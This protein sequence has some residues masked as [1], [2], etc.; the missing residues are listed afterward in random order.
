MEILPSFNIERESEISKLHVNYLCIQFAVVNGG[1]RI[2]KAV[3]YYEFYCT[4]YSFSCRPH[5]FWRVM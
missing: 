5:R 4:D 3:N 2:L 1:A